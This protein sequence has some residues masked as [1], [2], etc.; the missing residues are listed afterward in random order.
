MNDAL[1]CSTT[2]TQRESNEGLNNVDPH[3]NIYIISLF[4]HALYSLAD[5]QKYFYPRK[6][7]FDL[8]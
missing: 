2:N 3:I 4:R 6:T 1:Q 7:R 8:L 5:L